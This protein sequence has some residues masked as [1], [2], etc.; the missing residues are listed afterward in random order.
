MTTTTMTE[1]AKLRRT[2]SGGGERRLLR[3]H[4]NINDDVEVSPFRLQLAEN[5]QAALRACTHRARRQTLNGLKWLRA[6]CPAS[7]SLAD[8]HVRRKTRQDV[9]PC[10]STLWLKLG[11]VGGQSHRSPTLGRS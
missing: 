5:L 2:T 11:R 7:R 10:A 6:V 1:R 4:L 3:T 8:P 9:A